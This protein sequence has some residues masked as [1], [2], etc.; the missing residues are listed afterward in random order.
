MLTLT[1]TLALTLIP[2][3]EQIGGLAEHVDRAIK[4]ISNSSPPIY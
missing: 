2:W 1:L 4:V 3:M